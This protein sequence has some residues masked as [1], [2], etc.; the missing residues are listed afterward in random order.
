MSSYKYTI[1]NLS[2]SSLS[3]VL[4]FFMPAIIGAENSSQLQTFRRNLTT[5]SPL[6]DLGNCY[7]ITRCGWKSLSVTIL[8]LSILICLLPVIGFVNVAIIRQED[9][10]SVLLILCG[11]FTVFV[12]NCI[13]MNV[14]QKKLVQSAWINIVAVVGPTIIAIAMY[15]IKINGLVGYMTALF[16]VAVSVLVLSRSSIEIRGNGS[17]LE[18][19]KYGLPKAISG[20]LETAYILPIINATYYHES[21]YKIVFFSQVGRF[22]GGVINSN[23]VYARANG[24]GLSNRDL[25]N[26]GLAIIAC[27]CIF[28]AVS[29]I[30][31]EAMDFG[32]YS[33]KN[34]GETTFFIAVMLGSMLSMAVSGYLNIKLKIP[35][36]GILNLFALTFIAVGITLELFIVE[37][38]LAVHIL[39]L[40]VIV[41]RI[42]KN[43]RIR[44]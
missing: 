41:Y 42:F 40:M 21:A 32:F 7:E 44:R 29:F 9:A 12:Y 3:V 36:L 18:N 28:V 38:I 25:A 26:F 43:E 6:L 34:M 27:G 16:I 1:I 39:L 30:L 14:S 22:I 8:V 19:I 35:L 10:N 13:A 2:N 5:I 31:P 4:N 24:L 23:L 17:L 11:L 20:A 37:W 33:P 15:K